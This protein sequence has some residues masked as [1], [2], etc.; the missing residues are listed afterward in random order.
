[1]FCIESKEGVIDFVIAIASY[2]SL[3]LVHHRPNSS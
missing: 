3:G 2:S 1:M